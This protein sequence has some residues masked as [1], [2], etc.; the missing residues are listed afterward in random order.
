MGAD[1]RAAEHRAQVIDH[2]AKT[3][4]E[5]ELHL[6]EAAGPLRGNVSPWQNRDVEDFAGTLMAI[7]VWGRHEQL[8]GQRRFSDSRELA[9]RFVLEAAVRHLPE[10]PSSGDYEAPF[11]CACLLRAA[12][13]DR[14]CGSDDARQA[15]AELACGT[16]RAHLSALENADGREFRDPGFLVFCLA[17][18]ARAVGDPRAI[19]TAARF[20]DRHFGTRTP[21]PPA[22]EP[23]P[24]GAIFDFL[25]TS[26]TR[27]LATLTALGETPFVGAWLR[28]RV[29]PTMPPGFV[30]RPRDEHAWN[31]S[32]AWLAGTG[33]AV[34]HDPRFLDPYLAIVAALRARDVDG[35][36]ALGRNADFPEG[37]T[38][39]TWAWAVAVDALGAASPA[40]PGAG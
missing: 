11:G 24:D 4:R 9:W 7:W 8:S 20:A 18:Y 22:Q 25:S 38:L 31:A 2:L 10:A 17:E 14:A 39:P 5:L 23:S 33:Y 6:V 27:V 3:G 12:L 40:R 35:D 37:E 28:E 29:L 21:P 32:V 15:M 16:L 34:T 1:P 13:V 30:P 36:G 26:A 19:S